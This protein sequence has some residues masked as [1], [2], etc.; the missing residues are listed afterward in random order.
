VLLCDGVVD[1]L[2]AGAGVKAP[3]QPVN[4]A[5]QAIQTFLSAVSPTF[6]SADFD[7]YT[8]VRAKAESKQAESPAIRQTGMSALR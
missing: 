8:F 6:L 1:R 5:G 3:A 7:Q 4:N 2:T